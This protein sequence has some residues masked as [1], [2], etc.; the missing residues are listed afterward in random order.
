[1]Q[2]C[3]RPFWQPTDIR[4]QLLEHLLALTDEK[5]VKGNLAQY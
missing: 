2:K 5:N 3:E 4:E 1:M